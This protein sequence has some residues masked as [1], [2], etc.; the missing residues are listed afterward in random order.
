MEPLF[1]A[2]CKACVCTSLCTG[3]CTCSNMYP[4]EHLAVTNKMGIFMQLPVGHKVG[5]ITNILPPK[6]CYFILVSI[7]RTYLPWQSPSRMQTNG[8][9]AFVI[10]TSIESGSWPSQVSFSQCQFDSTPGGR[11]LWAGKFTDLRVCKVPVP[12]PKY[13]CFPI[14][15]PKATLESAIHA[16]LWAGL[17]NLS[18]F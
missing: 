1:M 8:A 12:I 16:V 4:K 2:E 15:F 6:L 5:T 3:M 14:P 7:L 17:Q 9:V 11:L 10:A 18:D 13:L